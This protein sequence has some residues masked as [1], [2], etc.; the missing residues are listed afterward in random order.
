[1]TR[2]TFYKIETI[3]VRSEV[4]VKKKVSKTHCDL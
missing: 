2:H 3:F 4:I 1:M